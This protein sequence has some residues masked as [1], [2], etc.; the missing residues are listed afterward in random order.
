MIYLYS[1]SDN[2]IRSYKI[3]L[4]KN[5]T[6]TKHKTIKMSVLYLAHEHS[7]C[8]KR[9][10]KYMTFSLTITY[11]CF[12]AFYTTI[13]FKSYIPP[14]FSLRRFLFICN[15]FNIAKVVCDACST[16]NVIKTHACA[17]GVSNNLVQT[18]LLFFY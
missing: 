4:H 12:L 18:N 7:I 5:N 9:A 15:V 10:A 16:T 1:C 14:T 8:Y 2:N 17:R 6:R 13:A 3:I 11:P